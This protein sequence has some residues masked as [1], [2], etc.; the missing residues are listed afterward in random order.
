M[1]LIFNCDIVSLLL[2]TN[3]GRNRRTDFVIFAAWSTLIVGGLVL[4]GGAGGI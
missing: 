1:Y 2:D 3:G 4:V